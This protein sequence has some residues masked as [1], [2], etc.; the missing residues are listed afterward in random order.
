MGKALSNLNE[1]I[2]TITSK[3]DFPE[4]VAWKSRTF[5][6]NEVVL[7]E[8]DIGKSFFVVQE[9][10]LRVSVNVALEERRKVRPGICE[11]TVGDIFG[12]VCLY[13]TG[14]RT[15]SVAAVT[16]GHLLEIDGASLSSYLDEHPVYGYLFYKGLFEI[17]TKRLAFENHRVESL[18]AW[19]LKA[20]DIERHLPTS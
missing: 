12:E 4:G 16:E 8:G 2:E 14:I 1:L 13:E 3:L 17:L 9:G 18:L 7:H 20:H 5:Q 15:A 10:K 11:L 6:A 19:G